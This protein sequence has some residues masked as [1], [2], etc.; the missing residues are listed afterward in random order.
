MGEWESMN[1]IILF[2]V[3]FTFSFIGTLPFG[4]INMTVADIAIRK[5][6]KSAILFALGAVIIEFGQG[7]ITVKFLNLFVENEVILATI[8]WLAVFIFIGAGIFFY[9]KKESPLHI[10]KRKYK[11]NKGW[12]FKG[13]GI[14]MLNFMP[15]PFWIFF[16]TFLLSNGLMERSMPDYLTLSAGMMIGAFVMFI[17]YARGSVWLIK[18]NEKLESSIRKIIAILFISLGI[19]QL[20]RIIYFNT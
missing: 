12:I 18:K 8:E 2:F 17:L 19:L 6:M 13:M 4:M 15:Y 16:S 9:L 11:Y 10:E 3:C 5:G 20:L 7:M 14:S 1:L